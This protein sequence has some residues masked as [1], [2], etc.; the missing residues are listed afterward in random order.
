MRIIDEKVLFEDNEYEYPFSN[1]IKIR[2]TQYSGYTIK[3][4]VI[5]DGIR[6]I[7]TFHDIIFEISRYQKIRNKIY[8]THIKVDKLGISIISDNRIENKKKCLDYMR[9]EILYLLI[10]DIYL[11]SKIMVSDSSYKMS[12]SLNLM[13][14]K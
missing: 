11:Y 3:C 5:S 6:K 10:K 8:E 9:N 12:F 2:L 14:F 7:I 13:I 4:S 1:I